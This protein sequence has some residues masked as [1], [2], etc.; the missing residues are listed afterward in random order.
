MSSL[1]GDR[2]LKSSS[3]GFDP[4]G[5]AT[6]KMAVESF[7]NIANTT[8]GGDV[9]GGVG[10]RRPLP[11]QDADVDAIIALVEGAKAPLA[12]AEMADRLRW[13]SD[14]AANALERGGDLGRLTF[15]RDGGRTFV[16]LPVLPGKKPTE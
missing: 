13:D 10:L 15:A 6:Q 7:L 2:K 1:F 4:R 14:R 3:S 5:T 9:G 12:I 16:G 8:I 11:A